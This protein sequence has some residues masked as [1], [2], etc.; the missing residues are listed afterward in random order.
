MKTVPFALHRNGPDPDQARQTAPAAFL[1]DFCNVRMVFGVVVGAQ[2]LAFILALAPQG[3]ARDLWSQLSFVSLFV[4]WVA[5]SCTALL[6]LSRPWLNRL[7]PLA[8][9]GWALGLILLATALVSEAAFRLFQHNGLGF[10]LPSH[11]HGAFVGRN[12]LVAAIIGVVGLR[13]C[14]IQ[15][16]WR[17]KVQAESRARI[18]ALQSRIRPH[19]M[20]NCMN[21]IASLTRTAPALAETVVEDLA[22]LFRASLADAGRLTTLEQELRLCRRYLHIESLRLG[23]RL[24]VCWDVE[25][26]PRHVPIPALTLQPLLEN[27]VYHGIEPRSEPGTIHIAA[28]ATSAGVTIEIRNPT[29]PDAR[30]AAGAGRRHGHHMALDNVR[31]RLALHFGPRAELEAGEEAGCFRTRLHLPLVTAGS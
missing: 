21:T 20:F 6:C 15:H 16:Q 13:Y 5:L 17:H 28:R 7:R 26:L 19:F 18:Q 2:L 8:A 10:L 30:G 11:W 12:L 27:A 3:E 29:V 22:E 31:E 23:D 9:G 24:R 14:Y 1:P 4:Q 25:G